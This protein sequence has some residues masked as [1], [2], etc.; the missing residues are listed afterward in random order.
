[1]HK[2]TS[3]RERP[4]D[5]PRPEELYIHPHNMA[6]KS[7]EESIN[8]QNHEKTQSLCLSLSSTDKQTRASIITEHGKQI[9]P[10]VIKWK[11]DIQAT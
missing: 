10:V 7:R 3:R 11:L 8:V 9:T 6:Q 4:A 2:N 1:M 5:N